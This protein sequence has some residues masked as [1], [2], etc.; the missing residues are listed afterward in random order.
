MAEEFD[1]SV[2]HF[3]SGLLVLGTA[4]A[5]VTAIAAVSDFRVIEALVRRRVFPVFISQRF[6][7][8]SCRQCRGKKNRRSHSCTTQKAEL[9]KTAS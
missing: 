1:P 2:D 5:H 8:R 6:A 4:G 7:S 9:T 3:S